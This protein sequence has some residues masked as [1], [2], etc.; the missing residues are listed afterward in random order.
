MLS[1]TGHAILFGKALLQEKPFQQV[2]TKRKR[3]KAEPSDVLENFRE[4][5]Y[6]D[7]DSYY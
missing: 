4:S 6:E 1:V 5:I 3:Q 2:T 7:S